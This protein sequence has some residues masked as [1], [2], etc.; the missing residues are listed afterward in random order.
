MKNLNCKKFLLIIV[1]ALIISQVHSINAFA[2]SKVAS[3]KD[4]KVFMKNLVPV[5]VVL[6]TTVSVEY[7]NP[8]TFLNRI[9]KIEIQTL[10]PKNSL[11]SFKTGGDKGTI[12]SN[13]KVIATATGNWK[14]CYSSHIYPGGNSFGCF[15][16][17]VNKDGSAKKTSVNANSVAM[18]YSN[19]WFFTSNKVSF[20]F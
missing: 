5:G 6:T 8:N 19:G 13:G 2:K 10:I 20:T 15:T 7:T 1:G 3:T 18:D 12:S 14:N 17:S 4:S 11:Y 9:S 16:Y